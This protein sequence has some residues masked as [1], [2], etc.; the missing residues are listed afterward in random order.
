MWAGYYSFG[1]PTGR[2]SGFSE[3]VS[4]L[5][6]KRGTRTTRV[7]KKTGWLFIPSQNV[8]IVQDRR[9]ITRFRSHH[10]KG[11]LP[12]DKDSK[13]QVHENAAKAL[14]TSPSPIVHPD[15]AHLANLWRREEK[16]RPEHADI[17]NG[18]PKLATELFAAFPTGSE[19][20]V[21]YGRTQALGQARGGFNEIWESLGEHFARTDRVATKELADLQHQANGTTNTRQI[22]R[23][24]EVKNYEWQTKTWHTAGR[25]NWSA[26]R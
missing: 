17:G 10:E 11:K 23:V 26:V 14:A 1:D 24:A 12:L 13:K 21:L 25:V 7:V 4:L 18:H 22:S 16:E 3:A 5:F 6:T 8:V 9:M 19:P 15:D 2:A 20:D